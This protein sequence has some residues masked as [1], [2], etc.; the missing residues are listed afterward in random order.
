RQEGFRVNLIEACFQPW[1][2]RLEGT[3]GGYWGLLDSL[4]RALK[5]P[6]G[7]AISN[8]PLWQ[9][10]MGCG[11]GFGVLVCGVA[12]LTLRRRPGTR[13]LAAGSGVAL[14]ATTAGILLGVAADKLFYES[15]GV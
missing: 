1:N 13:R 7:E 2:R 12:W 14:S 11:M 10:Q 9:L 3:V 6:P 8:F 15:Y 4:P 5:Y